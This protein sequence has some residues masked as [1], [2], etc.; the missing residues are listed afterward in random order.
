MALGI[1]IKYVVGGLRR[2]C[3]LTIIGEDP[4]AESSRFSSFVVVATAFGLPQL[5]L[6]NKPKLVFSL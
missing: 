6:W 3:L 2:F 4:C 5:T 1:A